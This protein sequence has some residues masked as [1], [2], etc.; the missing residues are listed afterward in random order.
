MPSRIILNSME[1]Q[2]DSLRVNDNPEI[3]ARYAIYCK[4][5]GLFWTAATKCLLCFR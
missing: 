1:L 4:S 3:N 5:R 2:A